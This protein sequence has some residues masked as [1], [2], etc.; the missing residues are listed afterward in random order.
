M[1]KKKRLIHSPLEKHSLDDDDDFLFIRNLYCVLHIRTYLSCPALNS[2]VFYENQEK[3]Y[4]RLEFTLIFLL[5]KTIAHMFL[6]SKS[7]KNLFF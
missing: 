2:G 3:S 7:E 6:R 5:F 4:F 1:L